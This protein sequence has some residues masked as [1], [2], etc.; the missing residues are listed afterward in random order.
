LLFTSFVLA[1]VGNQRKVNPNAMEADDALMQH[2]AAAHCACK[3]VAVLT[4]DTSELIG[5]D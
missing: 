3:M 1:D 5:S 4:C 2:C